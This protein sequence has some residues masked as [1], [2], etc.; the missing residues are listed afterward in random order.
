MD[1]AGFVRVP[2][3]AVTALMQDPFVAAGLPCADAVRCAA[4]KTEADLTSADGYGVLRLPQYVCRLKAE[5]KARCLPLAPLVGYRDAA[6]RSLT[7]EKRTSR[8][9]CNSVATDPERTLTS[10]FCCDAQRR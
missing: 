2:A 3:R 9:H 8:R 6:M 1:V 5:Q 4:L 10:S 7:G